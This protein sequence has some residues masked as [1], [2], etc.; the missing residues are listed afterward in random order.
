MG[1]VGFEP[2]VYRY[3]WPLQC[4][5]IH[6]SV[7]AKGFSLEPVALPVQSGEVCFPLGWA[8]PPKFRAAGDALIN[9]WPIS[10]KW[11]LREDH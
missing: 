11:L 5:V 8:T 9:L 6:V 10:L 7:S 3:L 1:A 4:H 2:T